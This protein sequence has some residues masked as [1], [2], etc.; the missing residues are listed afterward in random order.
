MTV[1]REL[2]AKIRSISEAASV[3]DSYARIYYRQFA[4]D[5]EYGV[6]DSVLGPADP[7]EV[8]PAV[9][10]EA[11]RVFGPGARVVSHK[12]GAMATCLPVDSHGRPKVKIQA[13]N[14]SAVYGALLTLPDYK[15]PAE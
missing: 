10:K 1:H 6:Y 14:V 4:D 15:E 5:V 13:P 9:L 2:A 3:V 8:T 12:N 7:T 11:E